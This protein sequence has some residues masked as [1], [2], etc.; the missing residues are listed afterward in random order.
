MTTVGIV[1]A[2][3]AVYDVGISRRRK[4]WEGGWLG[5]ISFPI[6]MDE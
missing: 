6:S 4:V 5:K 3:D 2:V 1:V